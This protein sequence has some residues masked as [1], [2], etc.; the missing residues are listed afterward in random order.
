MNWR[1]FLDLRVA[2]SS[3][4]KSGTSYDEGLPG[5]STSMRSDCDGGPVRRDFEFGGSSS[6]TIS[7][8]EGVSCGT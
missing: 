4:E 3:G 8:S 1:R 2:G 7:L 6:S 5:L